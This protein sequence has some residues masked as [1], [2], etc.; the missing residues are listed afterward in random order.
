MDCKADM[1]SDQASMNGGPCSSGE[2]SVAVRLMADAETEIM[3]ALTSL[4]NLDEAFR[5]EREF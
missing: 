1:L 5:V 4:T 3:T 2:I